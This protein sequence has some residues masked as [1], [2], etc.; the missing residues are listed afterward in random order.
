MATMSAVASVDDRIR[1]C[2]SDGE[3]LA[4][5]LKAWPGMSDMDRQI[6]NA[7]LTPVRQNLSSLKS[8]LN[9]TDVTS[10]QMD[11]GNG[12]VQRVERM[13][14]EARRLISEAGIT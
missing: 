12:V 5:G 2:E 8:A 11:R 3:E 6:L 9:G 7:D 4:D 10:G 1:T 14:A 13:I